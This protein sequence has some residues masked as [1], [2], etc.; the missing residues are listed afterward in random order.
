MQL[1]MQFPLGMALGM[2]FPTGLELLRR[3]E[4]RLLPWAWAVDGVAAVAATVL[5]VVLAMEIGFSNVSLVAAGGY[6]VG[7]LAL[8]AALCRHAASVPSMHPM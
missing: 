3:I 1:L 6:A 7:R 2:Y 8:L 5:A 4:Q